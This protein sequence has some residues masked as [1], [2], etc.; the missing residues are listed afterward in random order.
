MLHISRLFI[1]PIK[2]CAGSEVAQ[3]TLD[4]WGA[5]GDRRFVVADENGHFLTQRQFPVMQRICPQWDGQDLWVRSMG[6]EDLLVRA[7][8]GSGRHA[9]Q[10][11]NDSVV[12][13]DCGDRAAEWFSCVLNTRCR[14]Y[15]LPENRL[16]AE[17]QRP[18]KP[19]YTER[20]TWLNFAD[21]FPLLLINEAS[22]AVLSAALGRSLDAVRFRP[23]VVLA[24]GAPWDERRWGRLQSADG[25]YMGCC[26]P[27]ERCV[28]PTRDPHTLQRDSDVLDVL[29]TH[30]RIDGK[31]IFGQNALVHG[32]TVLRC[33]DTFQVC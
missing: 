9:V 25:G 5:V 1:H 31:I 22:L 4:A 32:L 24:G 15:R 10:V 11:W 20:E 18:V 19:K 16:S 21:G 2:S 23:N 29:K 7:E 28:I 26:K 8:E 27:C 14:L 13:L 12:A 3:L 30:C 6:F 33:G 17:D